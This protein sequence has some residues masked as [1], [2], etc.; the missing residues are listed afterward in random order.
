[1]HFQSEISVFKFLWLRVDG[2][3]KL[4]SSLALIL[5]DIQNGSFPNERYNTIIGYSE[6]YIIKAK[7][8][9]IG[10]RTQ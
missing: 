3:T 8:V 5:R 6:T 1:M 2:E 4:V 9:S 7:P 10:H